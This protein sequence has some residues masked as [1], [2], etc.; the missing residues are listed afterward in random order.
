MATTFPLSEELRERRQNLIDGA[1][2]AG[3]LVIVSL[4]DAD[5]WRAEWRAAVRAT[6]P[7]RR[8]RLLQPRHGLPRLSR[9]PLQSELPP[10][11]SWI[12][13]RPH[14]CSA[15]EIFQVVAF[16]PVGTALDDVLSTAQMR[17]LQDGIRQRCTHGDRVVLGEPGG[18]HLIASLRTALAGAVAARATIIPQP[19]FASASRLVAPLAVG[20]EVSWEWHSSF[21]LSRRKGVVVAYIPGGVPVDQAAPGVKA[22][23][24]LRRLSNLD[25]YLVQEDGRSSYHTPPAFLLERPSPPEE[26]CSTAS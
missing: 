15:S 21:G 26:P 5:A 23:S 10:L 18:M 4:E 2:K 20:T 13:F 14:I 22:S 9:P 7:S 24:R 6:V 3:M 25:R 16:V 8:L 19:T 11:G 12:S 1:A 17:L